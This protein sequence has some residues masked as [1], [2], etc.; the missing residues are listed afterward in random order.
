[1]PALAAEHTQCRSQALPALAPRISACR[2][3]GLSFTGSARSVFQARTRSR[4]LTG[5][6]MD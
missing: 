4:N 2:C 3:R 1:M 6:L 5:S